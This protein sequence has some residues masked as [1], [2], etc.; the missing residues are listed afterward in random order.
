MSG[1]LKIDIV[2]SEETLLNL[3]SQ[4]KTAKTQQRV[5]VLYWLKTKQATSVGHLAAMLG[6]HYT[7]VS[8]WLSSYRHGGI[9]ALLTI[10][11]STG[12]TPSI[13]P[14]ILAQL[15]E[16]LSDPE[17]FSSYGEIQIWLETVHSLKVS[18]KV[19]HDTVRYRLKAKLKV[20]R[21]VNI[22]QKAGAIDNFKKAHRPRWGLLSV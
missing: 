11:S 5:Q 18:Y 9:K 6:K 15:Q 16:E 3:L 14:E 4:Q 7:T 8:R 22:R 20:P 10:K 17:G 1:V 12:R 13:P 2:E 19:V 21:P